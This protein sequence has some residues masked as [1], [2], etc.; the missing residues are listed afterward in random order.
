MSRQSR[1]GA[2]GTFWFPE[3]QG[4]A[5]AG[6]QIICRIRSQPLVIGRWGRLPE[7]PGLPRLPKFN[8]KIFYVLDQVTA[9]SACIRGLFVL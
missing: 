2:A 6:E 9:K 4:V 8:S 7:L 1:R 5:L 3:R